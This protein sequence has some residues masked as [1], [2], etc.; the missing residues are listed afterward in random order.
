MPGAHL[1]GRTIDAVLVDA[2]GV[3]VDLNWRTVGAILARHGIRSD[4]DALAAADPLA[5]RELDDA[6]LIRGTVDRQRSETYLGRVLRHAGIVADRQALEAAT[7]EMDR[8]HLAEGVWDVVLPGAPQALAQLRAAGLPLALVSNADRGL[9][10]KLERLDLASHFNHLTI[11]AEVEVEKPDPRIFHIALDALGVPAERAVH[12]GDLYEVDI[13][14]AR[15]AGAEAILV[16][17]AGLSADRDCIRVR[18]L[19]EVPALLGITEPSR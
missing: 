8:V 17:A 9:R 5:R 19:A 14:G 2:G 6:E 13:V 16:D 11:S 4:L 10:G 12:V 3:V 7:E 15:A 1:D 18:A